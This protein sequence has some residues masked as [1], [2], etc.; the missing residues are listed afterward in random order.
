M[1]KSLMKT[2][3][4]RC[5]FRNVYPCIFVQSC[6]VY[7]GFHRPLLYCPAIT[8]DPDLWSLFPK[9]VGTNQYKIDNYEFYCATN[10]SGRELEADALDP[11]SVYS[12]DALAS[13]KQPKQQHK[14]TEYKQL[15]DNT[16]IHTCCFLSS[17]CFLTL[18]LNI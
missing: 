8:G 14:R 7:G 1:L 2:I 15:F 3:M 17:N 16:G 11:V 5:Q 9:T 6:N 4:T 12:T 18:S 13:A 10:L